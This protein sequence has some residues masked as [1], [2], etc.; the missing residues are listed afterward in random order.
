MR[1]ITRIATVLLCWRFERDAVLAAQIVGNIDVGSAKWDEGDFPVSG[2]PSLS[3]RFLRNLGAENSH[4]VRVYLIADI[5][6]VEFS[7]LLRIPI[8]RRDFG[9]C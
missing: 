7:P 4:H 3:G 6:R 2:S 8:S 1:G 5:S 9:E